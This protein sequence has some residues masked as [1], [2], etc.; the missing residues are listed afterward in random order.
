MEDMEQERVIFKE[1]GERPH[2]LLLPDRMHDVVRLEDNGFTVDGMHCVGAHDDQVPYETND[3]RQSVSDVCGSVEPNLLQ[4]DPNA[5]GL[6][7]QIAF[8]NPFVQTPRPLQ[9]EKEQSASKS[10]ARICDVSSIGGQASPKP[11]G[12]EVIVRTRLKY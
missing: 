4:S 1:S 6:H 12:L 9:E 3:F 7:A 11:V 8:C 5:P 2:V 10:V